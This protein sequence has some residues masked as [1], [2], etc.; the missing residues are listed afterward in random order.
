MVHARQPDHGT[1][2]VEATAV[3]AAGAAEVLDFVLD[4]D[5]YRLADHK[6][7]RIRSL[8]RHGDDVVVSMWTRFRGLPVAATQRMHLSPGER[9]DVHNEPSW[10]DRFTRF[11]GEF[12]CVPVEGGTQVTHRY[13]FTFSVAARVMQALLRGWFDRDIHEEVARLKTILDSESNAPD[14]T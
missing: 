11:H 8:E 1:I 10:Q 14:P 7:R 9:I 4:L 6:I 3:V 12:V 5:R 13:T 2:V